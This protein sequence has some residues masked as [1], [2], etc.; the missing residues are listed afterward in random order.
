MYI[1]F[2]LSSSEK[3]RSPGERS[4]VRVEMKDLSRG[5]DPSFPCHAIMQSAGIEVIQIIN[6]YMKLH[7]SS[8][9]D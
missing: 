6:D 3:S 1:D 5:E 9:V 7:L 8:A 4:K 2:L